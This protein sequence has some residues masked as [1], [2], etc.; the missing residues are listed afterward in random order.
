MEG[1]Y[2]MQCANDVIMEGYLREIGKSNPSRSVRPYFLRNDIAAKLVGEA[3]LVWECAKAETT[4]IG[5]SYR[6]IRA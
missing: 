3:Y 5:H 6:G 4:K 1:V 2:Q